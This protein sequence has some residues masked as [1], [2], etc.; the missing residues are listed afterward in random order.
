ML[1]FREIDFPIPSLYMSVNVS[2]YNYPRPKRLTQEVDVRSKSG[3]RVCK[4]PE[5]FSSWGE[6]VS[7][8]LWSQISQPSVVSSCP[9]S[10]C[11][12][13]RGIVGEEKKK[14]L[15]NRSS[16]D[17]GRDHDV[18]RTFKSVVPITPKT[19]SFLQIPYTLLILSV[20]EPMHLTLFNFIW[21]GI[22]SIAT[23]F[24]VLINLISSERSFLIRY[25]I[26]AHLHYSIP[27]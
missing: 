9:C 7:F 17:Q 4:I 15:R 6:R 27:L 11:K 16:D 23:R 5:K 1:F 10:L 3:R 19:S 18:L 20:Y 26:K 12:S 2:C 13:T 22:L 8:L 21:T 25:L 14:S 24:T